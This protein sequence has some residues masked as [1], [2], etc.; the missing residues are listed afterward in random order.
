VECPVTDSGMQT[1]AFIRGTLP[2]CWN[3]TCD[4]LFRW[5]WTLPIRGGLEPYHSAADID[6]WL[7]GV[8][9]AISMALIWNTGN[10][11]ASFWNS[12]SRILVDR[13]VRSR[14]RCSLQI[15]LQDGWTLL[16]WNFFE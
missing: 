16:G 4:A 8:G 2:L 6:L 7:E 3:L 12:K 14:P 5:L 13:H 10:S 9:C 15:S 1:L 11:P